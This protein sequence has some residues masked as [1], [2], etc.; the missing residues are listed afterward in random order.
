MSTARR[1]SI[2]SWSILC[3]LPCRIDAS[4]IA[5][6]RLFAAP[7]A[8][9]SPVKWRLRSSIGTTC[10][11][12]P[13]AAPPLI[14]NT[15]PSDGSRRHATGRL[16]ICAEPLREADERRRLALARPRRRHARHA[17]QLAVRAV[18][19]PLGH[20]QVDLRLVPAVRLELLALEAEAARDLLDRP[21]DRVLR[22]LEAALHPLLLL[23][24][25]GSRPP[26][27]APTPAGP[28]RSA[29]AR[30]ARSSPAAGRCRR[31]RRA[32]CRRSARP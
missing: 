29:R 11:I 1:Q 18:G 12:P 10:V 21:Q 32:C 6:S 27:P 19:E 15:G 4:S 9:M 5:A 2:R 22:D 7:I 16:P 25:N 13:P 14:P 3:G 28:R 30:T 31:A 20:R 8:W 24:V 17:D 26:R 23:L